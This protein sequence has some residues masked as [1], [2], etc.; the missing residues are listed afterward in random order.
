M[1]WSASEVG[2]AP[3]TMIYGNTTAYRGSP[4]ANFASLFNIVTGADQGRQR[5][6]ELHE[7][8]SD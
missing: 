2:A 6:R 7:V 8:S 5:V 4:A 3:G 1:P